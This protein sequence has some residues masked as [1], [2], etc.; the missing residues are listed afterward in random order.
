MNRYTQLDD[1]WHEPWYMYL[2][3]L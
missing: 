3:N 1:I 2:D